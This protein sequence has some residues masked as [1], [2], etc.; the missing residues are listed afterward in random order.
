MTLRV[1]LL[2]AT[3]L[4]LVVIVA[5]AAV[6]LRNQGAYLVGQLDDQLLAA[7]PLF[8]GPPSGLQVEPPSTTNDAPDAPVSNLYVG[9]MEDGV[10]R[11]RIEGQLLEDV[12][13]IDPEEIDRRLADG[14]AF[15]VDGLNGVARFRVVLAQPD[16]TGVVSVIALPLDEVDQAV[17]QLRWAL[18]GGSA[19]IATV[20]LLGMWWIQRLGLRPVAEVTA[21]AEAIAQGD[22]SQRAETTDPRTEAG[23]LATA[24]NVMLD[25]RDAS[26]EHLRRFVADASHELRTP[27]TSIRGYLDLYREG[28][29][30]GDGE[31]DDVI[32]RMSQ[33]SSRMQDLVEDLLLLAKLDEHRPLRHEPVDLGQLLEDAATDARVVQPARS[34]VVDIPDSPV[35]ALGDT[36]RLQQVVGALLT[37]ALIH[38]TTGAEIRLAAGR[39]EQGAEL[40]VSDNGPGLDPVDAQHVFER[41]YRGDQS[42]ARRTGGSGLGLAIAKSVVEAHGGS[43]RLDTAPGSGCRFTVRLPDAK[44]RPAD[45]QHAR[46]RPPAP[47]AVAET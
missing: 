10:L 40:T 43:I 16:G 4:I 37:N 31:L 14:K 36:Y 34:I 45:G 32:R 3:G 17:D 20:L 46:G 9:V 19:G 44:A 15:T 21:V 41:F 42:R 11:T 35:E 47:R 18:F 1:R 2:L 26:E 38:T 23:R 30:H 27:L 25:E 6:I 22:R 24:F 33:E 5:G 13:H 28:G 7:R 12:P 8:R 39:T 29:F